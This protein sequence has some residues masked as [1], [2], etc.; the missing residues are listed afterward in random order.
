M[1]EPRFVVLPDK[2]AVSVEAADRF[3]AAARA[4]V[5]DRGTFRVD[6]SGG[7]TPN[8]IYPLL[9]SAPRVGRVDWSRVEFF[10]GDERCVPPDHPDSNF[11]NAYR[12]FISRLPGVRPELIHR[13]P[14]EASDL[15]AAALTYEGELRLAFDARE[16][17]PAFDLMWLGMGPDGHTASLFPGTQALREKE[18][19]CMPNWVAAGNMWRMTL[20]L[21]VINA[22]REVNF[23]V[24]GENKAR[25]VAHVRSGRSRL[26]AARVH[27]ASVTW[28]LD[29][30]A[31]GEPRTAEAGG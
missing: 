7:T 31:A 13:M 22:A 12:M 25:A 3:I 14:A 1:S 10:W 15:E 11:G 19:W 6:L 18:R 29:A 5:D 21:P 9:A 24:S 26:P 28:L 27:A 17:P 20:T 8:M 16:G 30:P 4:A 23:L 2:D